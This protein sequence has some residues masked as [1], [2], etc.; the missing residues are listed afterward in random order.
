M[1]GAGNYRSGRG[2]IMRKL[3][4]GL[5]ASL[6]CFLGVSRAQDNMQIKRMMEVF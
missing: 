4:L 1:L 3:I 6:I 5:L 2:F